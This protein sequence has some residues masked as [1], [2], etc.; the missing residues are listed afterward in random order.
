MMVSCFLVQIIIGILL[1][2]RVLVVLRIIEKQ[3]APLDRWTTE[4]TE[5]E[6]RLRI[7]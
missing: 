5:G 6:N 7:E 4:R 2:F 3:K 1:V